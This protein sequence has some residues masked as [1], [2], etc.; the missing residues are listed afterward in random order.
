MK[1]GARGPG[2]P[3][4]PGTRGTRGTRRPR[5]P[6]GPGSPGTRRPGDRGKPAGVISVRRLGSIVLLHH[7]FPLELA[8]VLE[9]TDFQHQLWPY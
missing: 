6:G 4:G 3:G 1:L 8:G 9:G 7:H 2:G 5:G